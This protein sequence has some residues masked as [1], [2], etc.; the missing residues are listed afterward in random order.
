M[1]KI[2]KLSKIVEGK[3]NEDDLR[4][5]YSDVDFEK[6]KTIF[7]PDTH[8]SY[9]EEKWGKFKKNL[10]TYMMEL[11]DELLQKLKDL[12]NIK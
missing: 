8:N 10:A 1:S 5:I 2:D 6:F 12:P 11:N 9:L 7:P 3:V 4:N